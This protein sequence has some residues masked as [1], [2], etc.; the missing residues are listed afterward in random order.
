MRRSRQSGGALSEL[1]SHGGCCVVVGLVVA[2]TT[3]SCQREPVARMERP[4]RSVTSD[5]AGVVGDGARLVVATGHGGQITRIVATSDGKRL[6]TLAEDR[7]VRVFTAGQLQELV[8]VNRPGTAPYEI[9]INANGSRIAVACADATIVYDVAS[10]AEVGRVAG[11][12]YDPCLAFD[13]DDLLLW[14]GG[15]VRWRAGTNLATLAISASRCDAMGFVGQALVVHGSGQLMFAPVSATAWLATPGPGAATTEITIGPG[16]VAWSEPTGVYTWRPGD[17]APSLRS[18]SREL[19]S[20]A[21]V[22]AGAA[23]LYH[24]RTTQ[25]IDLASGAMTNVIDREESVG[26]DGTTTAIA[27]DET[28]CTIDSKTDAV[29]R[30]LQPSGGPV[31]SLLSTRQGELI[32]G[33]DHAPVRTWRLQGPAL[34]RRSPIETYPSMD[35][36]AA[37]SPD[38]QLVAQ[39][40][41]GD[42]VIHHVA[43]RQ[44]GTLQRGMFNGVAWSPDGVWIATTRGDSVLR[45]RADG[46]T[47]EVLKD[48]LPKRVRT[49]WIAQRG[50]PDAY[51]NKHRLR[52]LAYR[53][54]GAVLAVGLDQHVVLIRDGKVVATLTGRTGE[55]PVTALAFRPA[56]HE[57]VVGFAD[58]AL[59][60]W[61]TEAIAGAPRD[62]DVGA[63]VAAVAFGSDGTTLLVSSDDARIRVF[64]DNDAQPRQVIDT[65]A[66]SALA[67]VA[68][69][70]GRIAA[71]HLDGVVRIFKLATR[72]AATE[73]F[74]LDRSGEQAS[75]LVA[76]PDG[77]FEASVAGDGTRFYGVRGGAIVPFGP[78]AAARRRAG[79]L[80]TALID[81]ADRTGPGAASPRIAVQSWGHGV[82]HDLGFTADG[83]ELIARSEEGVYAFDVASGLVRTRIA[84][85][86]G[87]DIPGKLAV[88]ATSVYLADA[89][90]VEHRDLAGGALIAI[91]PHFFGRIVGVTRADELVV[92]DQAGIAVL[93]REP[94]EPVRTVAEPFDPSVRSDVALSADRMLMAST[95]GDG[96]VHLRSVADLHEVASVRCVPDLATKIAVDATGSWIACATP[97]GAVVVLRRD[98]STSFVVRPDTFSGGVGMDGTIIYALAFHPR[99]PWLAVSS[100]YGPY[101][102]DVTRGGAPRKLDGDRTRY[103]AIA[104][105]PDGKLLATSALGGSIEL[106]NPT[107]GARLQVL[108]PSAAR[109]QSIGRARPGE[110]VIEQSNA[111]R[112]W[113]IATGREHVMDDGNAQFAFAWTDD[114]SAR[115]F[116][117]VSRESLWSPH[118]I[119]PGVVVTDAQGG[120]SKLEFKDREL[121]LH[122]LALTDHD[123]FVTTE[124]ATGHETTIAD[125]DR[126]T[127]AQRWSQVVAGTVLSMRALPGGQLG[128]AIRVEDRA[129]PLS[130]R[131]VARVIAS[132]GHQIAAVNAPGHSYE[133]LVAL[134]GDR[135]LLVDLTKVVRWDSS[136]GALTPTT[137]L[138]NHL[139]QAPGGGLVLAV[140]THE[141]HVLDAWTGDEVAAG[142][143][144]DATIT[145]GV[146]VTD[147]VVAT[148]LDDGT[149]AMWSMH[150]RVLEVA[151]RLVVAPS[152]GTVFVSTD[153][154]YIAE[155]QGASALG[156]VFG[157][158]VFRFDQFDGAL[159]RP[160]LALRALG[161]ASPEV[162]AL[163]EAAYR[164]RRPASAVDTTAAT[165]LS[166]PRVEFAA[167]L[168]VQTTGDQVQVSLRAT[169]A[170]GAIAR[171]NI[172]VNG[173]PVLGSHGIDVTA[174][175][176]SAVK[177]SRGVVL[178]SGPNRIDLEA[179]NEQGVTGLGR[180]AVIT[181]E[182]PVRPGRLHIVAIGVS[183]YA[184]GHDLRFAAKDAV[185]V[186]A[187][188][189]K[190]AG[191]HTPVTKT[192]LRDAEVTRAAVLGLRAALERT[193]LED[194]VIV[195]VSG[196]GLLDPHDDRYV[197]ATHDVDFDA[198]RARGV[199]FEELEGL[200][201]GI[202]ARRRLM[203]IDTCHAGELDS[204]ELAYIK[205]AER[206]GQKGVRRVELRSNPRPGIDARARAL[207]ARSL[208]S[209]L[210]RGVGANILTASAGAEYSYEDR[211]IQN[212]LFARA[213]ID[214]LDANQAKADLDHDGAVRV[215]ELLSYLAATV[216][217]QSGG[218]Q[219]PQ[220]RALNRD[221]DFDL[222]PGRPHAG[223]LTH[224]QCVGTGSSLLNGTSTGFATDLA[225][226]FVPG[227]VVDYRCGALIAESGEIP[228]ATTPVAMADAFQRWVKMQVPPA[229]AVT[230]VDQPGAA[231]P[232]VVVHKLTLTAPGYPREARVMWSAL[233]MATRRFAVCVA[234]DAV[235]AAIERCQRALPALVLSRSP[236]VLP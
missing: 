14:R 67:L 89:S 212:G 199:L 55:E 145:Q 51:V 39:I 120:A 163:Y 222:T 154:H 10:G 20:V 211:A 127:L 78:F 210:R 117:E 22:E 94:F 116:D 59:R 102:Y 181:R 169:T 46:T 134:G 108:R 185:E 184:Q 34:M 232:G 109:V 206:A 70:H 215:T 88:A 192:I 43:D 187:A 214:G 110:L 167:P 100:S 152:R 165:G 66:P 203:M 103:D 194:T 202:P 193:A 106:F 5:G 150:G 37:L 35:G 52:L 3:T 79:V 48:I 225:A 218:F 168:P 208:F 228:A 200:L 113:D 74:A 125:Y 15:L 161:A 11:T 119:P 226:A 157:S 209:E 236:Q 156:M 148:L 40:E 140:G 31:R 121:S 32:V 141:L 173:I 101:L 44:R 179:E 76:G 13:G 216:G 176:R 197:L 24:G 219:V 60:M 41:I 195:F 190:V 57:L 213:V 29:I 175:H 234:E 131:G 58:G 158:E 221:L 38:E 75:W 25:R 62:R 223:F 151:G 137:I 124:P 8:R 217:V 231:G 73:L 224:D 144:A 19:G 26:L 230:S 28:L 130:S 166:I 82:I 69:P 2:M 33:A 53:R 126:S 1:V 136:T 83:R 178:E 36:T 27:N 198:P 160:H 4:A 68:L 229:M 174:Q 186:A 16:V 201:D 85:P 115:A 205:R 84:G 172:R 180:T 63:A 80:E 87:G 122:Q 143:L 135:W 133:D 64:A 17:T 18:S 138:A 47:Q 189:E 170:Q 177:L 7:I 77:S 235:P 71:G 12:G 183:R 182:A 123:L 91:W 90:N 92:R 132:D 9:A 107:S 61:D 146:F 196:H 111:I 6:A 112:T 114:G 93:S 30:C 207:A 139:A 142:E 149:V 23:L 220:A 204:D 191:Q 65:H 45:V 42:L 105:S 153:G 96:V 21:I 147:R 97:R 128:L 162:L 159:N 99:E 104:W 129:A 86:H 50:E 188:I 54:D 171:V 98:G 164:R 233:D 49:S 81:P 95:H 155:A 72:P 227:S 118:V 56:G